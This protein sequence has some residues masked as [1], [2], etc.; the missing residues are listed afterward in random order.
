[1]PNAVYRPTAGKFGAIKANGAAMNLQ[2]HEVRGS[3]EDID[4]THFESDVGVIGATALVFAEG[5]V[6]INA[7]DVMFRGLFDT[8]NNPHAA[9]FY[10]FPGLFGTVFCGLTKTYGYTM[11]YRCLETPVATNVRRGVTFEGRVKSNGL[12][13]PPSGSL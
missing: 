4:A 6:G 12:I 3:A 1:M 5:L 8:R 13:T 9:P 10:I 11:G 2:E 7:A